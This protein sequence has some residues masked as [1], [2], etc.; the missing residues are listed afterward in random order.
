MTVEPSESGVIEKPSRDIHTYFSLSYVSYLVLTRER[1]ERAGAGQEISA[2]LDTLFRAYAHLPLPDYRILTGRWFY[3]S[4]ADEAQLEAAGI[5]ASALNGDGEATY[6]DGR[7]EL[8]GDDEG[9]LPDG[10]LPRDAAVVVSRT[11]L[12]SMP[13]DWQYAFVALLERAIED[14]ELNHDNPERYKIEAGRWEGDVFTPFYEDPI[15]HYRRGR[16]H[17]EPRLEG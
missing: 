4:E 1:L 6:S 10:A 15:P 11:L 12:Q 14:A 3:L 7:D 13:K 8:T 16:T 5:S 9:F 2:M 17:V